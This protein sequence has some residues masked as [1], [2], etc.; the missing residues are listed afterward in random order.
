ML[1]Q[2]LRGGDR[3]S[4]MGWEVL[5]AS[6]RTGKVTRHEGASVFYHHHL[7][8]LCAMLPL[9]PSI[10]S[11]RRAPALVGA[12]QLPFVCLELAIWWDELYCWSCLH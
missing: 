2:T 5:L 1:V 10:S 3:V 6:A 9:I 11:A 8:S 12:L 7:I 4:V